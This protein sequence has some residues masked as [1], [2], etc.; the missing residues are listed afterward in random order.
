MSSLSSAKE[1]SAEMEQ[2]EIEIDSL[3]VGCLPV[4]IQQSNT[5]H[6]YNNLTNKQVNSRHAYIISQKKNIIS[7]IW[8]QIWPL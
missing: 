4:Q 8:Y 1:Y 6:E 3:F 5:W 7:D 2:Y